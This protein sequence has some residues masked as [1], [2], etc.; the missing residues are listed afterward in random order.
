MGKKSRRNNRKTGKKNDAANSAT[1]SATATAT[2]I[3][4]AT[5]DN[6]ASSGTN[7]CHHGSTADKFHPNHEYMKDAK[8]FVCMRHQV[9]LLNNQDSSK[10]QQEKAIQM[11]YFDDHMHLYTDPEFC[12]FIFAFCTQQYLESNNFKDQLRRQVIHVLLTLGLSCRY[13][14]ASKEFDK[15][16]RDILTD[17]GTI[18]VLVR[19]TKTYCPCMKEGKGIA[20]TMDKVGRCHGCRKDFPKKTLSFCS[21]CQF[22]KYHNRECQ[23]NH[24]HIHKSEC[25]ILGSDA[26][27]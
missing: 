18:K 13:S 20:K 12:Q 7:L 17:R 1:A 10:D 24:W 19:E 26:K 22:M 2:A 27:V 14:T 11:K 16:V 8:E 6:T 21:G 4:S 25:K 23:T 15:Y 9:N 5:A 3:A